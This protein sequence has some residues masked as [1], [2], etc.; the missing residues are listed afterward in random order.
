VSTLA[1]EN[2]AHAESGARYAFRAITAIRPTRKA[3]VVRDIRRVMTPYLEPGESI[4]TSAVLYSGVLDFGK[5]WVGT[6]F[7]A[8]IAVVV[9]LIGAI[10]AYTRNRN[11]Q[12]YYAAVTGQRVLMV[13][14]SMYV[15]RPGRL[16]LSDSRQGASLRPLSGPAERPRVC[17]S[18]GYRGPSGPERTLY[19]TYVFG[20]E[21]GRQLLGLGPEQRLDQD[22]LRRRVRRRDRSLVF[23]VASPFVVAVGTT[24]LAVLVPAGPPA[25]PDATL[26]VP[27]SKQFYAVAFSPD[28]AH[29]AA[30]DGN[31]SAYVWDVATRTLTATLQ[32]PGSQGVLGVAFSPDGG[33]VAAADNNG[34]TYIWELGAGA[35]IT[36]GTLTDPSSQGVLGV[37]FSPDGGSVAAADG[38]GSAYVWDVA[39]GQ[40]TSTLNDPG[41]TGVDDVAFSPDGTRLAAADHNGASYLWDVATGQ[42]TATFDDPNGQGVYRVVFS[43]DGTRLAAADYDGSIYLWDVATGQLSATFTDPSS[44]G[45]YGAAFSPNGTYLAAADRNG[46]IY[47]WDVATGKLAGTLTDPGSRAVTG[48]AFSPN[49]ADLAA[50]DYNGST[51]L[52]N[53]KWLASR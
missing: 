39:T 35:G 2:L 5:A 16:A 32:D 37:A 23:A 25:Q 50:A 4:E 49:G 7:L 48:V 14:V 1:R 40:L 34:S 13:E 21:V 43:P 18:V 6:G 19:Y 11:V 8:I 10:G 41:S 22:R 46:S 52:W 47:V 9:D 20:D 33:S 53:M 30:A 36:T 12:V 45:V 51:Y 17:A 31:G 42:L 28:G 15:R 26:A 24:L 27:G 29:V 3:S 38:N 44:Q